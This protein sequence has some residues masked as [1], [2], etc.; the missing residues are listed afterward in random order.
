MA[1]S[2]QP[3]L[4]LRGE[5]MKPYEQSELGAVGEGIL[6]V[7]CKCP[8]Q[9]TLAAKAASFAILSPEGE[10]GHHHKGRAPSKTLSRNL[11]LIPFG[12]RTSTGRPSSFS[13]SCCSPH[14]FISV[15]PGG[16]STSK[17]RSLPSRSSLRAVE[18]K[19]RGLVTRYRATSERIASRLLFKAIE[20][21]TV[22]I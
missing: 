17:S 19:T 21:F 10:E 1:S 4:S 18:P 13:R 3:I 22:H 16:A 11:L 9:A 8:L 5:D 2:P 12:V 15:V 7:R 14:K 20:G 6:A